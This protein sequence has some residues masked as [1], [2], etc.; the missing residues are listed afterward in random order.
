LA[1]AIAP[2]SCYFHPD[3][4]LAE[5]TEAMTAHKYHLVDVFTDRPFAGNQLAVFSDAVDV[6]E[7]LMQQ[8]ANELQLS[9]TTFVLPATAKKADFKV[10]IFTPASELPFAGHPTIGTAFVL[11]RQRLIQPGHN[12]N[13]VRLEEGVGVIPVEIDY[14]HGKPGQI[15]ME[16]LPPQFGSEFTNRQAIADML[17]VDSTALLSKC[18]VQ[19]V[20]CGVPF[21][22]VP[23]KTL[24][25]VRNVKLRLDV[26]Q[27]LVRDS[28][29][30][31]VMPFTTETV[32][33]ESTVHCRMFAPGLAILEDAATG[34][35]NGPLGCYLV[36]YGL[37]ER[38]QLVTIVSEQGYEMNRP[39]KLTII[40]G[41][42]GDKI[43]SVRVGGNCVYIGAGE[44]EV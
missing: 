25:A 13:I 24:E 3:T 6:P 32:H 4:V 19:A 30:P 42:D 21:L 26:W 18:P 8:L 35:A 1:L 38:Q 14:D 23:L 34:S 22:I 15:F 11:A 40:V 10:R 7:E 36:R 44:I 43:R 27:R 20:S 2:S 31:C 12:D 39:S 33:E 5:E 16:Q 37:V 29:A 28:E 17:S 9:E 41:S